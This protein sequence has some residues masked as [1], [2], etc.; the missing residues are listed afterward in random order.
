VREHGGLD[1]L[2][3]VNVASERAAGADAVQLEDR[4][5]S[6]GRVDE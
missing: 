5:R 1:D 4:C 2:D 3:Q 6:A